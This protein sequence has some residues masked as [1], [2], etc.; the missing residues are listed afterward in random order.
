MGQSTWIADILKKYFDEIH[1]GFLV[2]IGV[3]HVLNWKLMCNG[4][5]NPKILDWENDKIIRGFSH[6]IELLENGWTGIYIDSIDEF[7]DNELRPLLKTL[8]PK[9][10]FK[11]IKMVKCGA[12][13]VERVLK[14]VENETLGSL[15][16]SEEKNL[17][18]V[19]PYNY[20]NRKILCRKTSDILN[21]NKCP[22]IIDFMVIDVENHE[23]N[24]LNGL[25]FS[26][27]KVK[28]MLIEHAVAGQHWVS[29]LDQI[30]SVIPDEYILI[31]NDDIN[32][33]FVNSEFYKD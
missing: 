33:M 2:E 15:D 31:K 1:D 26:N 23:I 13:D 30:K 22:S 6:T 3:G 25:D 32:A 17:S 4:D 11:K 12:S 5:Y 21:E 14:V 18:E 7:I 24:V 9:N 19:I 27:Y 28:L 20:K 16:D 29:K 10:Q 8:L